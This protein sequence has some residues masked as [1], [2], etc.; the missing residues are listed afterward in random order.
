M[1]MSLTTVCW[2][3]SDTKGKKL[4]AYFQDVEIRDDNFYRSTCPA[5]HENLV[6][7]Q[8]QKFELLFDF[9][10]RALLDGYTREAVASMAAALERFYEFYLKVVCLKHGIADFDFKNSWKFVSAQSERQLGAF[11]FTYLFENKRTAQYE[12]I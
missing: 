4:R 10:A 1:K 7:I 9:G 12:Q 8:N 6:V 5:G 11:L 2:P 3:C